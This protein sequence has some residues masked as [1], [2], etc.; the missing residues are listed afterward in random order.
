M[1]KKRLFWLS[2]FLLM[3][4]GCS[5]DDNES[6]LNHNWT[7]NTLLIT[8]S[9]NVDAEEYSVTN[10]KFY[11]DKMPTMENNC[12]GFIF[13]CDI[14]KAFD[15]QR[16]IIRIIGVKQDISAFQVEETFQLN[17]FNASLQ[18]IEDG[19]QL[20]ATKGSIKLMNKK[21]AGDKDVLT[22]QINN[23]TFER[24]YAI[25]GIV[26]FEYEGTVYC[27]NNIR[28]ILS[29]NWNKSPSLL[30]SELK[31]LIYSVLLIIS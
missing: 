7:L 11:I 8:N 26:D 29:K 17:Q 22:F 9:E 21:K 10:N 31:S 16:L 18:L 30:V 20:G 23:L 14:E 24:G 19:M 4:A 3:L 5:S 15:L 6:L 13:H 2:V 27:I 25:N 28:A 1:K 12:P